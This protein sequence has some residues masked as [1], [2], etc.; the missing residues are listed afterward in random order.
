MSMDLQVCDVKF[1][2][3]SSLQKHQTHDHSLSAEMQQMMKSR[4]AAQQSTA[5]EKSGASSNGANGSA[6]TGSDKFS[7]LCMYC[8]QT[9]KTK[10]ELEKH[11]KTHILPSNQKCNICD[12]VFPSSMILAEHKLTHCKVLIFL[13]NQSHIIE[14]PTV[15][16]KHVHLIFNSLPWFSKTVTEIGSSTDFCMFISIFMNTI[17]N[18]IQIAT[19]RR[20]NIQDYY[21]P[22]LVLLSRKR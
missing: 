15:F 5:A 12:E 9:F 19:T 21:I 14:A 22:R 3:E 7:Q 18:Y 6:T 4:T 20:G 17:C 11:M 16:D 2:D 8:K 1:S 10:A 13:C